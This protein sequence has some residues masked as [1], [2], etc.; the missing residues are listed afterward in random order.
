M[1]DTSYV[2]SDAM[3][4]GLVTLH[5]REQDGTLTVSPRGDI[6]PPTFFSGGAGL[7]STAGDYIRFMQMILRGGEDVLSP[8]S[9]EAMSR[10]QIGGLE[11]VEMKTAMPSFSNDFE[12]FPDHE[13][14][15]GLGFQI[16]EEDIPGR[17]SRGS[18]AWA[19]LNNTYFWID[20]ERDLCGVLLTQILPFYDPAVVDLLVEFEAAIYESL[21]DR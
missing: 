20:P 13:S 16:N 19:G 18:L 15:F 3:R 12:I 8:E 10:D 4:A 5:R 6:P 17:R 9:I 1:A 14:S 2:L 21:A 7:Y 11:V